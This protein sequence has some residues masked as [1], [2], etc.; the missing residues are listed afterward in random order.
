MEPDVGGKARP[1]SLARER[2]GDVL[3]AV[4]AL[5]GRRV[6]EVA[7]ASG[8]GKESC[9]PGTVARR[10]DGEQ[11]T[12]TRVRMRIPR[13]VGEEYGLG[14]MRSWP[15]IGS[16]KLRA[17]C[18]AWLWRGLHPASRTMT[19][20]GCRVTTAGLECEPARALSLCPNQRADY[21]PHHRE[22]QGDDHRGGA[23]LVPPA[24]GV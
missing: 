4:S 22:W 15:I 2:V 3:S 21:R 7:G 19:V 14:C 6:S 9:A 10:G 24:V 5:D 8:F 11:P 17:R 13:P 23:H 1:I 12:R 20:R 16:A 18:C